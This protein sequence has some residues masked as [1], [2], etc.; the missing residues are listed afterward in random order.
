M[1]EKDFVPRDPQQQD[2]QQGWFL[3][4]FHSLSYYCYQNPSEQLS[5]RGPRSTYN[6]RKRV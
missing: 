1:D 5:V 4:N 2:Q 6:S 3:Q